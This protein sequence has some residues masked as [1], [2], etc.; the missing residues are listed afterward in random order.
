ML[1]NFVKNEYQSLCKIIIFSGICFFGVTTYSKD[2][3]PLNILMVLGSFPVIHDVCILNQI[4]GLIDRGHNVDIFA[5]RKRDCSNVQEDVV[6]YNL[7]NKTTFEKLPRSLNKYDVVMFQ[8]GH[9][10]FNIKKN[11]KFKGKVVVCLRGY[12]ITVFP[13]NNSQA[14]YRYAHFSDLLLPVCDAFKKLL[15]NGGCNP[16]KIMVQHSAIDCSRFTF[17][18]RM[19]VEN[20]LINIVSAGRFVEKKGFIYSISAIARIIKKYPQVRYTIIGDGVLKKDYEDLIKIFN[21]EDKIKIIG[22][23]N[24][25]D[26]IQLLEKA[27]LFVLSS[28]TAENNDQEGIPNVLKEAMAMGIVVVATDHSGNAELITNGVSGM[29]VPERNS[30]AI[31]TAIDDLL[32]NTDRWLAM[33]NMAVQKVSQEFDKEK[34]NDKLESILYKLVRKK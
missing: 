5:F 25:H 20:E 23:Q 11:N 10:L 19:L 28:V 12:D 7:I 14:Y 16:S 1:L 30:Y 22:W 13:K 33:Q 34:E 8:L 29:L 26:Y 6:K 18:P 17:K 4:T 31:Y 24:H 27:H 21:L 2:K 3:K 9:K 32:H 15:E